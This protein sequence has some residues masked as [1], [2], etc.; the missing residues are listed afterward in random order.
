MKTAI[1]T[2]FDH[3]N[4]GA[5]LQAYALQ[6]KIESY[7]DEACHIS[8]GG[9]SESA[10]SAGSLPKSPL[11]GKILA[12]TA[13]RNDNFKAFRDKYINVK[14]YSDS[15]VED[16]DVFITGSDQVFNV[17]LPGW[18][19]R[20]LLSFAGDKRR[21]AYAASFGDKIKNEELFVE[22][23]S[24]FDSISMREESAV[25]TIE[26]L[27]GRTPAR[28]VDP[29]FLLDRDEWSAI[30]D[31][32]A[33]SAEK[34]YLLFV[35]VQNNIMHF[36]LVSEYAKSKGLELKMITMS[37]F[38]PCGFD[39]WSGVRVEDYL[40]LI[41]D[42]SIVVTS[43]FHALAFSIIFGKEFK[44]LALVDEL[45]DRNCR[46]KELL[47]MLGLKGEDDARNGWERLDEE[48]T[49]SEKWLKDEILRH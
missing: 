9:S 29:V 44:T 40:K 32:S 41:R 3:S 22:R 17:M 1:T 27:I 6:R 31:S 26:G 39:P 47:D 35:M 37:Y 42:A 45:A 14:S 21:T 18:T 38:P 15:L 28:V 11:L 19:D 16:T 25:R 48:R 30:A 4:Y 23:L 34:P 10:P 33:V 24:H 20:F 5:V 49:K 36:K 7:G 46:I 2:F 43:S 12:C 13:R 8:F